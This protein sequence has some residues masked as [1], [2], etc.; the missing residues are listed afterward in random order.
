[1]RYLKKYKIFEDVNHQEIEDICKE[2]KIENYT[3]NSDGSVDVDGSVDIST[4]H[5]IKIPL[6][7]GIVS[8]NFYAFNNNFESLD[9]LPREVG[10]V[11][12][13]DTCGLTSLEGCSE[14]IGH[15]LFCSNNKLT[16]LKGC[17]V[18][19]GGS[20]V[21]DNNKLKTLEG[22]PEIIGEDFYCNDNELQSI[23]FCS[24]RIGGDFFVQNNPVYEIAKYFLHPPIHVD[25]KNNRIEL[26]NYCDIIRGDKVILPR[27]RYF[28]EELNITLDE[29]IISSIKMHYEI[30]E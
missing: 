26:F 11:L 19:I 8:R 1:M 15:G 2:F 23:E 22:C 24:H 3:I 10:H 18:E 21:C 27:L 13:L 5:L 7:F 9:G 6:K 12:H 16:S 4:C 17:P 20:L 25:E 29:K 28:F 30:I 14:K